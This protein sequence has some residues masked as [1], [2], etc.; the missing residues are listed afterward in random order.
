MIFKNKH[1]P[2]SYKITYE[3]NIIPKRYKGDW[4]WFEKIEV[5][6]YAYKDS[7]VGTYWGIV[8]KRVVST[9]KE[10]ECAYWYKDYLEKG[11]ES[12]YAPMVV[13]LT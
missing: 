12:I 1:E 13:K 11:K 5:L 3:W 10:I 9:C 8:R 7:Q 6:W 2:G 4:Y